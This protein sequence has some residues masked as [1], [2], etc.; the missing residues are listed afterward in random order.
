MIVDKDVDIN[1]ILQDPNIFNQTNLNQNGTSQP[2]QNQ[3]QQHQQ[4]QNPYTGNSNNLIN[5]NE[6]VQ[7]GHLQQMP[8]V[9]QQNHYVQPNVNSKPYLAKQQLINQNISTNRYS[10]QTKKLFSFLVL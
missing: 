10:K 6:S 7:I 4:Q 8:L 5:T 9:H 3:I 1:V 2:V